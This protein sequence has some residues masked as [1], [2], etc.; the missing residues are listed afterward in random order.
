MK[1]LVIIMFFFFVGC[2]LSWSQGTDFQYRQKKIFVGFT[3][4]PAQTT[5]SNKGVYNSSKL[6]QTPGLNISETVDLGFRLS[7]NFSLST[8]IAYLSY[9]TDLG[10]SEYNNS[11][12]SIDSENDAFEMRIVG[13][14]IVEKQKVTYLSIPVKIRYQFMMT[15]KI[16]IF[17][18]S[19]IMV[20]LPLSKNYSGS[21]IFDYNGYYPGYNITLYNLPD[22]GFPENVNLEK[23]GSL[24]LTNLNFNFISSAGLTFNINDLIGL[25]FGLYYDQ[26]LSSISDYT[27]ANFHLTRKSGDYNSLMSSTSD[28]RLRAI[29]TALSVFIHNRVLRYT[30]L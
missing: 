18:S 16:G 22:Y 24:E 27:P 8:G 9:S 26:S 4:L 7:K 29:G 25:S 1:Y 3:L 30:F 11:Y 17:L 23:T 10:M 2:N 13:S 19:G 5:I 21:G 28:A 6:R 14:G 15:K 12:D 20:S